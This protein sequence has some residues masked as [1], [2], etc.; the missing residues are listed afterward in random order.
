MRRKNLRMVITGFVL[1][2]LAL[3]FFLYM[4]S[5]AST[6]NDPVALMKTVGTV[7]GIVS[8]ISVVLII[9]G[10]VGKRA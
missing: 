3:A 8:G 1:I 4:T 7:A 2:L 9:I 10:L 5:I 6:S